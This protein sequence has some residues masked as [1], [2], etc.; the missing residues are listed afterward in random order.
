VDATLPLG[1]LYVPDGSY[2][3]MTEWVLPPLQHQKYEQAKRELAAD[4][5][6]S[7]IEPFFRAGG[8]WRNFKARYPESDEMYTRMLGISRRL[9][10]AATRDG[11]DPDYLDIAR[12]EL[13]RGQ[14]NCPYW[15]GAFGG[16]YLP[17]LRNSIYH[18][19]IAAHNA[20]D[21]AEGKTGPRV[22]LE[23]SDFNLDARLEVKLE[24]DR[25]VALV[26]PALG[27]HLYELDARQAGVNVLA[28]LDRRPEAYHQTIL[29]ALHKDDSPDASSETPASIHDRVVLKHPGLDRLIVYD[30]YPRKALIDHF[31]PIDVTLDDLTACGDVELGDFVTGTY[32]ARVQREPRRVALLMERPGLADGQPV[33]IRKSIEL[34]A[35]SPAL[36]VRYELS[37]LP[38]DVCLHFAVEL[39][40]A[41]MAGHAEDRYYSDS[42]GLKHGML[43]ARV[44]LAHT[45]GVAL[46]DQ[47]LDLSVVL[48]WSRPG[49]LWCHPIETV[50][51]SESGFE[52]VYQSSA[53]IPHWHVTADEAGKWDVQIRLL[54]E[55]ARTSVPAPVK[56]KET[57]ARV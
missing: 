12:R 43:D 29:E 45:E 7:Q 18:S 52:G 32:L 41:A 34:A 30:R 35:G 4:P 31:Y 57:L 37:E 15:H 17:H 23:V 33:R 48:G 36:L 44:D 10:A 47:W 55:H 19:L 2:R 21:E 1:K 42:H 28:T 8:Y 51:Q 3:E 14:C 24:S 39:N 20:L 40:F 46:V 49:G 56:E 54:L 50:S 22:A 38:R 13:Y 16:L 53:V 27:G 6:R 25:L 26:R 5:Q 11:V 9:A